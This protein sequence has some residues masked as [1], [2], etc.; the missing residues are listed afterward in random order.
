MQLTRW[1]RADQLGL[2]A[3]LWVVPALGALS[4]VPQVV[5]AVRDEP[6]EV[7]GAL[8]AELVDAA[9]VVSG[10]VT[11]TLVLPDPTFAERLLALLPAASWVALAA[12]VCWLLLGVAR[13][14]RDGDPFTRT[15]ARR[16][17]A[18]ALV[19]VAGGLLLQVVDGIATDLLLEAA[20][21]E[22][23]SRTRVFELSLWPVP[24]GMLLAFLAEVFARGVRLREDVEGLV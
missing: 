15:N 7:T 22:G 5:D 11:G 24:V 6:L 9:D 23:T 20:L 21:P 19:L 14:L 17:V 13:G 3:L 16:L 10:L 18:L 4:L 8:P 12:V 1:S 2:E